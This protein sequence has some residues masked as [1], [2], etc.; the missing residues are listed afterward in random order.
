MISL[1]IRRIEPDQRERLESW[2]QEVDGPRRAEALATLADEGVMHEKAVILDTSDGPI[3]VY[4][5]ESADLE[6]ARAVAQRSEHGIDAEHR[7][8]MEAA[9][10]GRPDIAVVL[11]LRPDDA[12]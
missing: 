5:M 9:V 8:V 12:A 2:L 7:E 3:L 6:R 1:T 11:D 10:A 4:A